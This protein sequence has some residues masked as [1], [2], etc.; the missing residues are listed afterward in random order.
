[1][2][3]KKKVKKPVGKKKPSEPQEI[4]TIKPIATRELPPQPVQKVPEVETKEEPVP[5]PVE[6]HVEEPVEEPVQ[7]HAEE[8]KRKAQHDKL[9]IGEAIEFGWN[10][11]KSRIWFFIGIFL[12]FF[13]LSFMIY[14]AKG[15]GTKV[16]L[17]LLVSGISVGYIKLTID[18]VDEKSP[19]FKMLF[20][21]YFPR[22]LFQRKG[23]LFIFINFI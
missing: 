21:F 8:E 23:Y 13:A 6:E 20:E 19:E 9:V 7:E 3:K 12:I 15:V 14:G 10:A 22:P 17:G 2:V 16:V 11:V 4:K 5:Q 1:M 18:I